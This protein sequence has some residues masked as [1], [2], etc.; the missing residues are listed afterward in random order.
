MPLSR[1]SPQQRAEPQSGA[2]EGETGIMDRERKPT[3][4]RHLWEITPTCD[5]LIF[6]VVVSLFWFVYTLGEIFL[7]LFIALILA[8][9]FNPLITRLET[10]RRWPRP[11]TISLLL[12]I[13][14][15]G[16]IAFFLWL[17]PLLFEQFSQLIRALP[18]Y[19]NALAKSYNLDLGSLADSAKQWIATISAEPEQIFRNI[20]STTGR[21]L[22]ILTSAVN[23]VTS[24][25]LWFLLVI[26]AF[27]F[28]AWHFNSTLAE[29]EEY[30][31]RS[32]RRQIKRIGAKMD[33]AIGDFFRGRLI[34]AL[35]CG[36]L[37]SLGWYF[38]GVPYW[39]LLGMLTGFLNIFPYLS[40]IGWPVAIILKYADALGAGQG[41]DWLAVVVWPSLVYMIVQFL[42]GWILTPW[43]QS[44]ENDLGAG[45][46]LIVVFIGGAFAGVWGLLFSIPA[47]ACLKILLDE[48]ALP[49]LRNWAQRH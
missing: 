9:V 23:L 1:L 13:V 20:F 35:I 5:L 4:E 22:G 30:L 7:P 15:V 16:V 14:T 6:L 46:V 37:F 21:A 40:I 29:L 24:I 43:I 34:I 31:P 38:S 26:V 47:A 27:F 48:V 12:G 41:A 36:A 8:E 19:M 18:D 33:K 28:F 45:T 39:F 3:E 10:R 25:S 49:R 44:G 2:P 42:E 11:L 17:G 32:R